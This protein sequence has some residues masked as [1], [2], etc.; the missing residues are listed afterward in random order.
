MTVIDELNAAITAAKKRPK[1]IAVSSDTW[2]ALAERNL[3]KMKT[4]YAWGLFETHHKFP[5]YQENIYVFI[6]PALDES[7]DNFLLPPDAIS[8]T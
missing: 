3:V 7:G 8:P 2:R 5:A 4:G 6:N 1:G